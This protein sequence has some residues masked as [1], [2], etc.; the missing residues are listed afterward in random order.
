MS[1]SVVVSGV[2][3]SGAVPSGVELAG[4]AVCCAM[5]KGAAWVGVEF[6]GAAVV[7]DFGG[8]SARLSP[9]QVT[10]VIK[11]SFAR[12]CCSMSRPWVGPIDT[13]ELDFEVFRAGGSRSISLAGFGRQYCPLARWPC[14][15]RPN[16]LQRPAAHCCAHT[17]SCNR[18]RDQ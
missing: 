2:V 15:Y 13:T 5:V 1:G 11:A 16:R 3:V 7:S 14:Q 6:T 8:V 18:R 12:L 17:D 4:A 10:A 9:D